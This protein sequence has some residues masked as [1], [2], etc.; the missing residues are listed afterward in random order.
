MS[1]YTYFQVDLYDCPPD[2]RGVVANLLADQGFTEDR[3]SWWMEEGRCGEIDEVAEAVTTA[4][5]GAT[6]RAYEN[7]KYE[8]LG[9]VL[10][11]VPNMDPPLSPPASCDA[12]GEVALTWRDVKG[13]GPDELRRA[14]RQD[15]IDEASYIEEAN[16]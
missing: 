1:D 5:P 6:F 7:P 12:D 10:W 9:T 15:Y 13:L 11:H 4:A 3:D 14:F 2:Q 16:P 8:W